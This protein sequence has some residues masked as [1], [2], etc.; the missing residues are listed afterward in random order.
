MIR[1][2]ASGILI[3]LSSVALAGFSPSSTPA[4]PSGV[5][6]TVDLPRD[7]HM[8]NVGGSDGLGLCVFTSIRHAADW[9]NL[10]DLLDY[11][12]WMESRPGGGYPSKVDAT[13]KAYCREKGIAIP[14][15]IQHT[16]GDDAFLD[17]AIKTGRCPCVTYAGR[18]DFYRGRI[19]HM[20]NLVYLDQQ[21]AAIVDNNRP[22]VWLWMT[23]SEFLSRWR[24]MSG[25]WAF[26]FLAPPPPPHAA[27]P[28]TAPVQGCECGD[29]CMCEHCPNCACVKCSCRDGPPGVQ[30]FGQCLPGGA[31]PAPSAGRPIPH[32]FAVPTTFTPVAPEGTK[33]IGSGWYA[34]DVLYYLPGKGAFNPATSLWAPFDSQ[35]WGY[36]PW[37]PLPA[38]TPL[39]KAEAKP[40]AKVE[41]AA[42]GEPQAADE[43]L[44]GVIPDRIHEAPAYSL[45]GVPVTKEEAHRAMG[46]NLVDDSDRWHVTV[47]GDRAFVEK[48]KG[49]LARLSQAVKGKFHVQSYPTDHWAVSAFKLKEGVTLRK[50]AG[51]SRVS[52]E[53]AAIAKADYSPDALNRMCPYAPK[54]PEPPTP[55]SPNDPNQPTPGPVN[56]TV[57]PWSIAAALLALLLLFRRRN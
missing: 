53:A 28:V 10:I 34:D 36:G 11:R 5:R 14:E 46:G 42:P 40:G 39:P 47:V 23:R 37:G 25:G 27:Q 13:L 1:F 20:V 15:Y 49:D 18:D 3:A 21:H 43:P 51:L 24:D 33:P 29:V 54:P 30:V 50:E 19:A 17:L 32:P 45:S 57:P 6:A 38:G 12:R 26:V 41:A 56:P 2:V 31:C 22:G 7:R 48:V 35:T 16:G 9:Q 55:P 44:T 8:K 52:T 4:G